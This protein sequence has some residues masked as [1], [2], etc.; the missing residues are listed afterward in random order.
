MSRATTRDI[1]VGTTIARRRAD[2]GLSQTALAKAIG[3]QQQQVA[4]MEAGTQPATAG[5]I[6]ELSRVLG[7]SPN[8]L[9]CVTPVPPLCKCQ[10]MRPYLNEM[11]AMLDVP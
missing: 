3:K 1:L 10:Q 7:L 4:R 11:L 5:D 6:V 8:E 9:L 2:L